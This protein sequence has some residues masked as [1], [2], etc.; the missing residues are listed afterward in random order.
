[1]TEPSIFLEGTMLQWAV[2]STSLGLAKEC[3]RKYYYRIVLGKVPKGDRIHITFGHLY[4]SALETYDHFRVVEGYSHP[5]AMREALQRAMTD[6]WGWESEDPNK[7]RHTLI[8]SVVWY[9]DKFAEDPLE[10]YV[11]QNGRP[12]VEMSF[13]MELDYGPVPGQPYVLC[14]YIDRVVTFAEGQYVLD[15]KTT[16]STINSYYFDQ[17]A[18]DNQFSF[19]S[20]I[21]RVLWD[22]PIRGVIID[23]A[24][25][26]VGFTEFKRGMTF[27]NDQVLDEWL[28][29]TQYWLAQLRWAAEH[30]HWPMNDKSCHKYGGCEFREICRLAPSAR[31]PFLESKYY[32]EHW[33][34]LKP[35]GSHVEL[36]ATGQG[37]DSA[38]S[39][40]STS[41][42]ASDSPAIGDAAQ[43][44]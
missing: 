33:N 4:H 37:S 29:D 19:Y 38:A 25:I 36:G 6:S 41:S 8:R 39:A 23:A 7:N 34:P 14:G 12:A 24:Q 27:R 15:R 16:K 9:L 2:D 5:D 35:R 31:A 22:V 1:M 44:E 21:A 11:L 40:A 17:Y 30:N 42:V 10:T 43:V 26:A 28:L 32:V 20:V 3:L 18:P 13:R